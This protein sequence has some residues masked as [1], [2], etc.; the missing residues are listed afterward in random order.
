MHFIRASIL[1]YASLFLFFFFLTFPIVYIS[2]T[3][4]IFTIIFREKTV[5][6][7][8]SIFDSDPMC[9]VFIQEA[10]TVENRNNAL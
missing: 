5:E 7:S 10:H 9:I 3:K 4:F 1:A 2:I 6:I 8:S